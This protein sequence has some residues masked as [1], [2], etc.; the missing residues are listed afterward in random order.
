MNPLARAIMAVAGASAPALTLPTTN[1]LAAWD[2]RAGV[3]DVS[4]ACSAW[5]DQSGN[6]WHASQVIAGNRPAISIANGFP[7]LL[8]DGVND[9]LSVPGINATA[10]PKSVYAVVSPLTYGGVYRGLFDVQTGR[11]FCGSLPSVKWGM[12]DTADR[13]SGIAGTSVL[14]RLAFTSIAGSSR[15]Y[16]NGTA[17]TATGWTADSVIGGAVNIGSRW[18][19]TL[20]FSGHILFLAVYN[21]ARNTAVEDYITQEWGV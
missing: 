6:G 16:K 13:D 17:G 2:A 14:Q 3:T 21:A 7:S 10:G 12:Y 8:F 4:G 9:T 18:S 15:V 5:A 20:H 19:G 1:L 11:M